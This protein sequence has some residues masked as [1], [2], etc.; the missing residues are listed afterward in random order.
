MQVK[1]SKLY[2]TELEDALKIEYLLPG[3]DS[4]I[5]GVNES[6][7]EYAEFIRWIQIKNSTT[8][9]WEYGG[10]ISY[11]PDFD[12]EG[13]PCY[14]IQRLIIHP[15]FRKFGIASQVME[16]VLEDIPA[17][18]NVLTSIIEGNTKSESL[19]KKLGF[20]KTKRTWEDETIWQYIRAASPSIAD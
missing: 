13:K 20:V 11:G 10:M 18:E 9:A 16:N 8:K 14:W 3:E 12:E 6:Y 17:T 4:F 1:L 5:F 15:K 2:G 7:E 19:F